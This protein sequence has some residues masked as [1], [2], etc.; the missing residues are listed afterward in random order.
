MTIVRKPL[1]MID[2]ITCFTEHVP[3]NHDDYHATG[4]DNLYR[5]EKNH[6]WFITR[7]ERIVKA[8]F[9]Y[10]EKNMRVLE[11]GAGTAYVARGLIDVGYKVAVGEL[12]I[13]GLRYAREKGIK[14]C[15]QFD[16]FDPPFYEEFDAVGMFDVLEHLQD[17]ELALKKVAKTLKPGGKLF[18]TVPAH[19]WLWSRDDAIAYHK[20]RYN[21]GDL[22]QVVERS[23]LQVLDNKYIFSSIL[24]LLYLRH[25][26][27]RDRGDSVSESDIQVS[28]VSINP[29]LNKALLVITRLENN[30]SDWLPNIAGG[31]LLLVAEK[32]Q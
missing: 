14:E 13:S 19:K 2:G 3:V 21:K 15:Y 29:W 9:K 16:L 31:S 18:V 32:P 24:P 30:L 8:F 22:S 26:F 20:K 4:I 5:E 1:N 23:G 7:R 6:F 12:H 25:L 27:N 17:D 28:E 11:I 10:L